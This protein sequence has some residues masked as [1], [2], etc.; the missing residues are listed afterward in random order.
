MSVLKLKKEAK[1]WMAQ[2]KEDYA[3]AEILCREAKFAQSCFYSQQ[4]TEKGLKGLWYFFD[5][6]PWGHSICRLIEELKHE[7]QHT[8]LMQFH[9]DAQLL[10]RFYIPTRYPNGLPELIP[11]EAY[12]KNDAKEGLAAAKRLI[13]LVKKELQ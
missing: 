6:E 2:A 4:A 12:N 9:E 7:P 3:V 5:E 1:R 13:D 10:D 11:Q 8:M